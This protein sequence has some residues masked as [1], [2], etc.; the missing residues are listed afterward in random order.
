MDDSPLLPRQ[1]NSHVDNTRQGL[2]DTH[3]P[4][5]IPSILNVLANWP[6]SVGCVVWFMPLQ[7]RDANLITLPGVLGRVA[8]SGPAVDTDSNP[9]RLAALP[10]RHF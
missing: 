6:L 2:E 4:Q 7:R 9:G 8:L 3:A 5:V 1:I 10:A